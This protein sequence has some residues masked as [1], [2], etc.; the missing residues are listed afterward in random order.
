VYEELSKPPRIIKRFCSNS[1]FL[2]YKKCM[3]VWRL[4]FIILPHHVVILLS[5]EHM[6]N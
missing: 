1:I 3:L 6:L 5:A 4:N 2:W